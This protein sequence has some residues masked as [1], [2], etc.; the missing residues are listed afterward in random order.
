MDRFATL[1]AFVT[2]VDHGGFAPAARRL[3]VAPSSLTR[4]V[5]ALEK[6]LGALLLNRSTRNVTLTDAGALYLNEARR[7]LDDLD[8][9]DR[10]VSERGGPP[11]GL[12]RLTAPVAFGRLHVA[13]MLPAFLRRYPELRLEVMATDA[14]SN[15][16]E[17]RIDVAVRLGAMSA[18]SLIARKLAPHRRAVCASPA[19]LAE[20]DAPR[21]PSDLMSHSCLVYEYFNGDSTWT[22]ARGGEREKV[23]VKGPLRSSGSEVLREAALGGVGLAL[24]PTWLIGGDIATGALVPVLDDWTASP[25]AEEGAIWACYPPNRRGVKKVACFLDALARHIGAPAYWDRDAP[26]PGAED[27][28][29]G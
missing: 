1:S 26:A 10:T 15:L 22:L 24:L 14:V 6:H 18:S 13:P 23:T 28:P 3:G 8:N 16:V 27:I 11:S 7:I 9:A 4:Q 20:H 5:N 29:S 19:Y 21:T 17:D 2:V 12:L 25:S